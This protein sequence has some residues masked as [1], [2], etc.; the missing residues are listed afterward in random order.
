MG[1]SISHEEKNA[2]L[3]LCCGSSLILSCVATQ[4][5]WLKCLTQKSL[6]LK[7]GGSASWDLQVCSEVATVPH[8]TAPQHMLTQ[9]SNARASPWAPHLGKGWAHSPDSDCC[10]ISAQLEEVVITSFQPPKNVSF[11]ELLK[12]KTHKPFFFSYYLYFSYLFQKMQVSNFFFSFFPRQGLA[13][14]PRLA[15]NRYIAQAGLELEILLPQ[16]HEC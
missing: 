1:I 9:V 7:A 3:G 6:Y 10:S 15:W 16:P 13:M 14:Q 5:L 4:R 12:L 2:N 8:L 11:L